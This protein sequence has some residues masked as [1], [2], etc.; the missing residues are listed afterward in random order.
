[1]TKRR[2]PGVDFRLDE[3]DQARFGQLIREM[4]RT[5]TYDVGKLVGLW[6]YRWTKQAEKHTT[7]MRKNQPRYIKTASLSP[8]TRATLVSIGVIS[9]DAT[10][11]KASAVGL[12]PFVPQGRGFAKA[13]WYKAQAGLGNPPSNK[14]NTPGGQWS[15]VGI[16]NDQSKTKLWVEVGSRV[17][18]IN[19]I[20]QGGG[21]MAPAHIVLNANYSTY[22]WMAKQLTIQARKMAARWR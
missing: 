15:Q 3:A 2:T 21:G 9:A 14:Y 12:K 5:T 20:D 4:E 18:Y 6:G 11:V 22:E 7:I 19:T 8:A 13:G 16:L 1:M 10:A 17:P